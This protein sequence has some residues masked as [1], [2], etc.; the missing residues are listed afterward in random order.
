MRSTD[1]CS[2]LISTCGYFLCLDDHTSF[3]YKKARERFINII[4][5]KNGRTNGRDGTFNKRMW[6]RL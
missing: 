6:T 5:I 3:V 4:L 2:H 1:L